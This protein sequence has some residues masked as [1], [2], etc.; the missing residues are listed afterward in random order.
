[1]LALDVRHHTTRIAGVKDQLRMP[2]ETKLLPG[3][4]PND[5]YHL[6]TISDFLHK[7]T[8][9]IVRELIETGQLAAAPVGR[10]SQ[11]SWIVRGAALEDYYRRNLYEPESCENEQ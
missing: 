6:T 7:S 4:N 8:T 1:M 2:S 10:G 11:R 5:L 9:W 3:I